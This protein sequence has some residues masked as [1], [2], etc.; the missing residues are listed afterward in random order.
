MNSPVTVSHEAAGG[1]LRPVMAPKCLLRSRRS[2]RA[3]DGVL[4]S[5]RL[6][7]DGELSAARRDAG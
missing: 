3:V 7:I 6:W 4:R 2:Q 5:V 1:Q